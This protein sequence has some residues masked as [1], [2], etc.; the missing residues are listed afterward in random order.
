MQALEWGAGYLFKS[1]AKVNIGPTGDA[2]QGCSG[3]GT[4]GANGACTCDS[5]AATGFFYGTH[6]EYENECAADADCG[7]NGKCI[8]VGDVS[9]PALQVG[10]PLQAP[11]S[12]HHIIGEACA[13]CAAPSCDACMAAVLMHAA[14]VHCFCHAVHSWQHALAS[15]H[16]MRVSRS[17]AV[18]QP[19]CPRK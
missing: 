17:S 18:Y 12:V 4:C 16:S 6:C 2:C 1:C 3:R 9:G 10:T 11:Q 13:G 14:T 15:V 19:M 8:D 5:S 7:A